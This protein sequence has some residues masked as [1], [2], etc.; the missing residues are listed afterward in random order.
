MSD[1]PFDKQRTPLCTHYWIIQPAEGPQS[2]GVCRICSEEKEFKNYI[3]H[4][5][6][7]GDERLTNKSRHLPPRYQDDS[8]EDAC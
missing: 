4:P 8:S 2:K 7:W 3:D 6:T 1:S 5:Y